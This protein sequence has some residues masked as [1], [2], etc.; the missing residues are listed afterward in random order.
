MSN[1]TGISYVGLSTGM[2]PVRRFVKTIKKHGEYNELQQNIIGLEPAYSDATA[3]RD[4]S[5]AFVSHEGERFYKISNS[6]TMAPFFIS[7]ISPVDHWLFASSV[8]GL[9]A[10]RVSPDFAL[11]PYVAVDKIHDAASHTGCQSVL[12]VVTADGVRVWEPFNPLIVGQFDTQRNIYKNVSGSKLCF[13]EINCSLGLTF[14]YTWTTS[15][16]FGFVRSCE[17][18]NFGDIDSDVE[19]LDGLR[20]ILPAGTP[21]FTQANASNLVDA[22][23]WTEMD[24]QT[25]LA[26]YA[27]YS[28]ISDRA[29]PCESLRANVVY[30]LGLDNPTVLLSALQVGAFRRGERVEAETA[31]RGIRG[32]YFV[33]SSMTVAARTTISWMIVADV[34]QSQPDVVGLKQRLLDPAL[35]GAEIA[36]SI[37]TGS[38]ELA[39]IIAAADGFQEVAEET[40]SVHHY[41]NVLFNV[42]RGGIFDQQ[43]SVSKRDFSHTV[44][45]FNKP[46]WQKHRQMLDQLPDKLAYSELLEHV[47]TTG[48]PQL[49]RLCLEYLPITFGRRHG[50][51]SRPWNKFTIKLKDAYGN[52]LLSYE[53]NWRDIFQNWEAL[54]LSYPGFIEAMIAKFVNASTADGYNPY[55]IT[56]EGIDWEVEDPEN[57]WSNIGYWGDHQMIYLLKLLELS[58]RFHPERL[59]HLLHKRSFSYANVPYRIRPFED[60]L[61]SPKNTV[62]YDHEMAARIEND[63]RD[64]GA[65][66]KLLRDEEG[67]VCLVTLLEKL[68]VTL[69]CKLSNTVVDGGVWLNTQRPEWND[70][71]NALVGHGLSMVTLYYM[72]RYLG[73]IENLLRQEKS[74]VSLSSNVA[75]WLNETATCLRQITSALTPEPCSAQDRQAWLTQ[76]GKAA[77]RFR[78]EVYKDPF[79]PQTTDV[80]ISA[81]RDM[82]SDAMV[83]VDHNIEINRRDDGLYHAYNL[84]NPK[85]GGLEVDHLYPMLEGQVAVLSSGALQAEEAADLLDELFASDIFRR[86]QNSFMLYPDR[87]PQ[88]FL[89]KNIIPAQA[90][91]EFSVVAEML[92]QGDTR[93]VERDPDGNYRFNADLINVAALNER[94]DRVAEDFGEQL[95]TTRSALITLYENVFDHRSFT[96]RSGGMFGFEGLGCIYWHMVSKLLLAAQENYFLALEHGEDSATIQRLGD[97][98]YGVRAGMGFNKTPGEYGAFPTD[99]YSHTPKHAGASQ[100]GMTGLVKEEILTRFGELGVR[101]DEGRILILPSLLRQQE[102]RTEE[103]S[104]RYLDVD[105]EWQSLSLSANG[106]AFTWCQVPVVYRLGSSSEAGL[107]VELND[108][109]HADYPDFVMSVELSSALF[110]RDGLVRKITATLDPATL[111]VSKH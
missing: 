107:K 82:L 60:L 37:D 39:K 49:E 81:I 102:F 42:L 76:M 110:A 93:L 32:A 77:C 7:L 89:E 4:A 33:F 44:R 25:G 58:Q 15:D 78:S 94:L 54:A 56:K 108:G 72:R 111:F 64:F 91:N 52:R 92:E 1:P 73:F 80:E 109:T 27:L 67:N 65:D 30:S 55:R 75:N 101:V 3:A 19:I 24:A 35:L 87:T 20:N 95:G 48:D 98:Y 100:P 18:E 51:P 8:G 90:V 13:E 43:Y 22:Y 59:R 41:A 84:L 6:D 29:E 46:T 97:L 86:D 79:V 45:H 70:A 36:T 104:F 14:R 68:L 105:D 85:A 47:S 26:F 21:P 88:G 38:R 83:L 103:G 2:L 17:I 34:E 40:V 63:V 28:G 10:G 16:E 31:K 66:A 71:N 50:D 23:K 11:F 57:P 53:G 106:L 9:T 62:D 12:R 61:R 74:E 69:L 5:G 99:P 96:G